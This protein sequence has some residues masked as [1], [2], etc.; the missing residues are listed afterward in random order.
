MNDAD[1]SYVSHE[2]DGS[3][4]VVSFIDARGRRLRVLYSGS[5]I[6]ASSRALDA[7]PDNLISKSIAFRVVANN[8][9]GLPLG[10]LSYLKTQA[11]LGNLL[12][13][14]GVP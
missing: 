11:K 7:I 4:L 5:N 3:Y 9:S 8:V 2:V 10:K 13:L 14:C 12:T 1:Y 6:T